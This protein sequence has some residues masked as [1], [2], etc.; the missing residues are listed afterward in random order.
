MLNEATNLKLA[1]RGAAKAKLAPLSL[2]DRAIAS[3][4]ARALLRRQAAWKTACSV[5]FFASLPTELNVWPLLQEALAAG[6]IVAL[7]RYVLGSYTACA[8]EHP[9]TD[10]EVGHFNI[11]EPLSFCPRIPMKRLDLALVPGVAFDVHGG[12]LGRGKG[13]YDRMLAAMSG[14]ICGVGFDQQIVP[15]LPMEP[16]DIRVNCILTPTRWLEGLE[17]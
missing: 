16:H 11:R 3:A 12:R 14:T 5:L 8:I 6:K 9:D 17:G 13:F 4:Q 10:V 15:N 7:P 1:L 2:T